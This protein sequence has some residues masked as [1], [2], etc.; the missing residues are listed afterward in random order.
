MYSKYSLI[1]FLGILAANVHLNMGWRE[2][3]ACY[4]LFKSIM[5]FLICATI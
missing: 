4:S 2:H 1:N 5:H 3:K